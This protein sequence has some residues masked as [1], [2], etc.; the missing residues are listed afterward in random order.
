MSNLNYFNFSN[1]KAD[2]LM[3]GHCV[4]VMKR[5]YRV[6]DPK[7][8]LLQKVYDCLNSWGFIDPFLTIPTNHPAVMGIFKVIPKTRIMTPN[9]SLRHSTSCQG[10]SSGDYLFG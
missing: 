8:K 4:F 3:D 7:K 10:S 2:P 1:Q 6:A 9:K 5:Y